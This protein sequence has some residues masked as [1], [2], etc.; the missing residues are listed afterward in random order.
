M[1]NNLLEHKERNIDTH[2]DMNQEDNLEQPATSDQR[3]EASS[4]Q[5]VEEPHKE[6]KKKKPK[7]EK[8][9]I[10]ELEIKIKEL[11]D[12]HLRLFAEFENYRKRALTERLELI[13]TASEDVIRQLLPV[14]D[15]FQ[16]AMKAMDNHE[17]IESFKEGTELIYNKIK[18]ILDQKG[19][20]E[21]NTLGE[22]FN[23]DFHE[24]LTTI[25]ST[26]E[27][28]IGKVVEEIQKGYTL[29]GKVIRYAKVIVAS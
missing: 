12:K 1:V 27:E 29:N 19:L 17:S 13:K 15:D 26:S 10:E 6:H 18:T 8:E 28:Q 7:K 22:V 20:K 3:P 24:A 5:P 4:Q 14:L 25:P 23:T 9:I 11:N 2:I 21:M 16:R